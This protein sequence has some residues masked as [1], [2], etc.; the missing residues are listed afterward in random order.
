M[1]VRMV[2]SMSASAMSRKRA[3]NYGFSSGALSDL[4][5][6]I[7]NRAVSRASDQ[8]DRL[9]LDLAE[10]LIIADDACRRPVFSE[11][12]TQFVTDYAN[13]L[14]FLGTASRTHSI[15]MADAL[16]MTDAVAPVATEI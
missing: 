13:E 9:A 15:G 16:R 4:L 7:A 8:T 10:A 14:C 6:A 11:T 3:T 2:H 5:D 12:A 1:T